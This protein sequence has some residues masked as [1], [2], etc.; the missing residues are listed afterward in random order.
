V[1]FLQ[2]ALNFLVGTRNPGAIPQIARDRGV[3]DELPQDR[4]HLIVIFGGDSGGDA[5][6]DRV[7][8]PDAVID[9]QQLPDLICS[10]FR[11]E[12]GP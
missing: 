4:D 9:V 10:R 12:Q 2:Q 5:H 3:G 8:V 11:R 7:H 1:S 6:G